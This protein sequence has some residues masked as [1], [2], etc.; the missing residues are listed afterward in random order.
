EHLPGVVHVGATKIVIAG[1][2]DL[3]ALAVADDVA[4]PGAVTVAAARGGFRKGLHHQ[5]GA[6]LAELVD[7]GGAFVDVHDDLALRRSMEAPQ[8]I[9]AVPHPADNQAIVVDPPR[10]DRFIAI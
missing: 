8:R 1:H 6:V 5:H 4:L 3:P 9:V 2:G 10:E 7:A